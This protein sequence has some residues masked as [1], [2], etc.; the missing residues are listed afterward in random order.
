MHEGHVGRGSE[1]MMACG[2]KMAAMCPCMGTK[3]LSAEEQKEM[4]DKM[5]AF[6]GGGMMSACFEKTGS[7]SVQAGSPE[8]A[9]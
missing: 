1:K 8:K 7:T 2:A 5:M 4:R 6:C 9:S 3:V